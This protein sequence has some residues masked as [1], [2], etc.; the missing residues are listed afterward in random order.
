LPIANAYI[1]PAKK[2]VRDSSFLTADNFAAT[3]YSNCPGLYAGH[4]TVSIAVPVS[5]FSDAEIVDVPDERALATPADVIVVTDGFE[6]VHGICPLSVKLEPSLNDPDAMNCCD[7]PTGIEA[8]PGVMLIDVGLVRQ[9][10]PKW[11]RCRAV[12]R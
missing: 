3:L 1:T 5:P 7:P 9:T 8:L 2:A 11:W 6:E 4:C 10:P 12:L